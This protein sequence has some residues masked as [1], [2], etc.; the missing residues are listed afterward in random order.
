VE[1]GAEAL[2]PGAPPP[3]LMATS[4]RD[5]PGADGGRPG[6]RRQRD[7]W[8]ALE[9]APR[10]P[11]LTDPRQSLG[12]P[13]V[14]GR[15][16]RGGGSWSPNRRRR[17]SAFDALLLLAVA[18]V[19]LF[20]LRQL[21]NATR[22]SVTSIGL[23]RTDALTFDEAENLEVR[24]KV[25]PASTLDSATLLLDGEPL[26]AAERLEDGYR[27]SPTVPLTPGEH[28]LQLSV[29]RP[30][31]PES[32]FTWRFDV[33][34]SP[35]VLE[36]ATL[37]AEHAIDEPV[38]IQ[39]RVEDAEV[40]T[41]GG[42]EVEFEDD[43]SFELEFDRPPA[44][45]IRLVA[46]DA[47]GHDV[48]REIFIP[49]ERPVVRGVHMSAISWRTAD[50]R[51]GVM[52]LIDAG[53][54]NTV[55]L[56][57]KDEGGE[58]GYDSEVPLAHEI[59]AVRSYYDLSE[60][61]DLLHEKGV[62][63]IGRL[64]AFRDPILAKEAW[65]D[66]KEDWVVQDGAGNMHGAYGGFTNFASRQVQQYNLDIAAEAAAAGVDEILWDYIRRPEGA[67]E[68]IRFP[69][70][71][72]T[73]EAVESGVA[74]FL[75]RSHEL[76]RPKGVFQ[77]ASVFGVAAKEP[78]TIGQDVTLI[79]KHVDYLAPMVYPSLFT[80]SYYQVPNP[81]ADPYQI[82]VRALQHFRTQTEGT[83]VHDAYTPWLQDFSLGNRTYGDAQ[84]AAQVKAVEDLGMDSWLLWSP[85]VKYH[86]GALDAPFADR[87]R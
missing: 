19:A 47:A 61:V 12:R 77:G 66:G 27:W 24:I 37:L 56:D 70:I 76:L 87:D 55:E 6:R 4:L 1:P 2:G 21:W 36:T 13:S 69:G 9:E 40:L 72:S 38:R 85:R 11:I 29:P 81:A 41:V 63:V 48:T 52:A 10:V 83:A 79:S 8:Q 42:D 59:G 35:P 80:P 65:A 39:G 15:R 73:V 82:V 33:D 53:K 7:A 49:L 57:L 28:R 5:I 18:L 26:E 84:V 43:G 58:V 22:V 16:L 34:V 60:A 75:R 67:L 20:L 51:R 71:P 64:V 68:E 62:R 54:I 32:S 30:I 50:L 25:E 44:G 45:P 74:S 31:L 86:A 3:D 23:E 78:D 14:R 17:L 46:S